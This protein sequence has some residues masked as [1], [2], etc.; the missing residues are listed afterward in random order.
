[1]N[2]LYFKMIFGFASKMVE[3]IKGK[4]GAGKDVSVSKMI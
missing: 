2:Y 1:M 3:A 4:I